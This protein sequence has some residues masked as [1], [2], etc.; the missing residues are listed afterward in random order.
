ML[1]DNEG[2]SE[3]TEVT[4]HTQSGREPVS[5]L[6]LSLRLDNQ[7]W[8]TEG[9]TIGFTVRSSVQSYLYC[10]YQKP[11][12]PVYKIFP[13]R[14]SPDNRLVAQSDQRI[15]G[16]S[17]RFTL[18]AD[19][20]GDVH[21]VLCMASHG[22]IENDSLAALPDLHPL[23]GEASLESIHAQYVVAAK[24]RG[25]AQPVKSELTIPVK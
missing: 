12:K 18:G 2:D 17:D 5:P 4:Q 24:A 1:T 3:I 14:F 8:V 20:R 19:A 25:M 6:T 13:N 15:P 11:G 16:A 9:D 22:D 23:R 7:P 10:Y 21:N